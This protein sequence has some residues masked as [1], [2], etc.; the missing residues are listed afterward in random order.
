MYWLFYNYLCLYIKFYP[1]WPT[2]TCINFWNTFLSWKLGILKRPVFLANVM[3]NKIVTLTRL[4]LSFCTQF[5]CLKEKSFKASLYLRLT[6]KTI[7]FSIPAKLLI[8]SGKIL[9]TFWG[10]VP[11]RKLLPSQPS[12]ATR[13]FKQERT[14]SEM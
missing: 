3:N 8:G 5:Y 6:V 10:W 1:I 7:Y 14:C 9:K 4:K 2:Y 12:G 11:K 13:V